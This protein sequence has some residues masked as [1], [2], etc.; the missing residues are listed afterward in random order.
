M[1]LHRTAVAYPLKSQGQASSAWI[2]KGSC[3]Q[4]A[5]DS[6]Q[7]SSHSHT[8]ESRTGVIKCKVQ[9][10][11]AATYTLKIQEKVWSIGLV[12]SMGWQSHTGWEYE[13]GVISRLETKQGT[14]ATHK[15]EQETSVISR[16]KMHHSTAVIYILKSQ[17]QCCQ[18][19]SIVRHGSHSHT[20]EKW[21]ASSVGSKH[22]RH[23][24]HPLSKEQWD[25]SP[26]SSS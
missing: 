3:C 5:C 14:V 11:T 22:R 4:Q 13:T 21:E 25:T 1:I 10:G 2:A 18:A 19:Q 9:W 15:L 17:E 23:G 16:L 12:H 20:K 26:V 8:E 7:N 6:A 24:S